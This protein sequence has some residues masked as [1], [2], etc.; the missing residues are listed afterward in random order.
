MNKRCQFCSVAVMST[1]FAMLLTVGC[2]LSEDG[3]VKETPMATTNT[4]TIGAAGSTFVAPLM[5]R[6]SRTYAQ[7]HAVHV[8][9]RPIGSGAGIEEMKK[10]L[11]EFGASDAP[12]SD[13]Q[14]REIGP[15]I[16]VPISAGPVC[17]VYNLPSLRGPLQLSAKTLAGIY[18]G[19]IISWQDAAVAKDNPGV[20]LPHSAI[21][22]VHRSD[23]SG[24]TNIFT[25]YLSKVSGSWSVG[26]GVGLSVTWPV[27]LGAEG[28]KGL[29]ATVKGAPGTIGYLELNYAKQNGVSVASI[30]NAAGEF[31][32]PTPASTT[33]A[34][35][36]FDEP[37]VHDVRA[38]I[39]DP[40]ASAKDAYP[41]VGM[42]FLLVRKDGN[43]LE[44]RQA[45]KDFIAYALSQGQDS[46]EE[47]SY[48]RLPQSVQ[49]QG[50]Q[51][52]SQLRVD[53]HPMR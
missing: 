21:I 49:A 13:D 31:V 53:G 5:E 18:L 20:Q 41:I 11:L 28:S 22:V 46:A 3:K 37:L 43:D 50:Q 38:P 36:A 9:Y 33:K 27:G 30:Q 35:T 6:W 2:D 17:V 39:V 32:L 19:T 14:I 4:R 25:N 48:A 51:L 7:T 12:L 10:G 44:D 15:A 42:T 1:M 24:T 16:Q 8:N 52:L 23:G 47:L 34:I 45:V 40:P 26:P 29:A